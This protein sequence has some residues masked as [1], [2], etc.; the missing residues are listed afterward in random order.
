[1]QNHHPVILA[2]FSLAQ[3]LKQG[4]TATVYYFFFTFLYG[5]NKLFKVLIRPIGGFCCPLVALHKSL[6]Y[7]KITGS[8]GKNAHIS[9]SAELSFKVMKAHL[10]QAKKM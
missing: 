2:L 6:C 3:R 1:M 9:Q 4:E 8:N 10:K 5:L 7:A